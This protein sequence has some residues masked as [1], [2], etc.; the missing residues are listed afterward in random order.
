QSRKIQ[1][2]IQWSHLATLAINPS[3]RRIDES[4]PPPLN[5]QQ[6]YI[7]STI[8]LDIEDTAAVTFSFSRRGE[9]KPL[10]ESDVQAFV[11][12]LTFGVSVLVFTLTGLGVRKALSGKGINKAKFGDYV[13]CGRRTSLM[14]TTGQEKL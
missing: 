2:D 6:N 12:N 7:H 4:K 13:N 1:G 10:P 8:Q 14:K 11:D 3:P 9:P 5:F